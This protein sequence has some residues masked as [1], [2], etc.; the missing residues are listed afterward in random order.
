LWTIG[1]QHTL[2]ALD[3]E[4]SD[5]ENAVFHVDLP[6]KGEDDTAEKIVH[7]LHVIIKNEW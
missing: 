3:P 1:E 5:A 2:G 7:K 4:D 6:V